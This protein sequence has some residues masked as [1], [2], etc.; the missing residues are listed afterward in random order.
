MA[1]PPMPSPT[2]GPPASEPAAPTTTPEPSPGPP[3]PGSQGSPDQGAP[4]GGDDQIAG[5]PGVMQGTNIVGPGL[6]AMD[7]A[8]DLQPGMPEGI[9]FVARDR[10]AT[11]RLTTFLQDTN[12]GYDAYT[13]TARA[14]GQS[15]LESD[16]AAAAR[17]NQITQNIYR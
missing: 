15:Y 14:S 11:D 7:A 2:Q 3:P 13:N 12:I 8:A 16:E 10:T 9:A 4:A 17:I 5:I 1:P 6:M